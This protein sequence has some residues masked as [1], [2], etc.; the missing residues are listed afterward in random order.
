M[1]NDDY[2]DKNLGGT[3][4]NGKTMATKSR[5]P[6]FRTM[7]ITAHAARPEDEDLRAPMVLIPKIRMGGGGRTSCWILLFPTTFTTSTDL[8]ITKKIERR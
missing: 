1:F 2:V 4:T 8:L 7:V 5:L 3:G 6:R